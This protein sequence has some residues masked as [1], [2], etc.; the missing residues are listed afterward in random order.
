MIRFNP[1]DYIDSNNNKISSPW[2]PTK[3][4]VL[5]YKKTKSTIREWES[6]LK[7]LKIRLYIGLILKIKLKK[8]LEIIQLLL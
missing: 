4:G 5:T 3:D 6:R 2:S 1:D 8:Q 7:T